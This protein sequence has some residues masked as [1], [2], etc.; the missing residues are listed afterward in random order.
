MKCQQN[1]ATQ[2]IVANPKNS[3]NTK[4]L[5]LGGEATDPLN[6]CVVF[7]VNYC[8]NPDVD[9]SIS[10]NAAIRK[11]GTHEPLGHTHRTTHLSRSICGDRRRDT[12]LH[13]GR[14]PLAEGTRSGICRI[15]PSEEC[16]TRRSGGD[17]RARRT[18]Q[19]PDGRT[20]A[21]AIGTDCVYAIGGGG[22]ELASTRPRL[23]GGGQRGNHQFGVSLGRLCVAGPSHSWGGGAIGATSGLA[24]A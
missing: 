13:G 5:V 22:D 6:F 9:I 15:C 19:K 18:V 4:V 24:G 23:A 1:L 20:V 17:L 3:L 7:L 10:A 12:S 16:G 2:V 14:S 11:G 21:C 8:Y